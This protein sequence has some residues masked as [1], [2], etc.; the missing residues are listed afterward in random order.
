MNLGGKRLLLEL[1][2]RVCLCTLP[3]FLPPSTL[4]TL[5]STVP[6]NSNTSPM[7][8]ADF[9]PNMVAYTK[10]STK[11]YVVTVINKICSSWKN[12]SAVL[13]NSF[14]RNIVF[15]A[16]LFFENATNECFSRFLIV[17][18]GPLGGRGQQLARFYIKVSVASQ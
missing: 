9:P 13:P 11:I 16:N 4:S 12:G 6:T 8:L 17:K 14:V 3:C 7:H 18:F 1:R 5:H 10:S 2:N 15:N